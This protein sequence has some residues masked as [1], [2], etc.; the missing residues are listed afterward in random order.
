GEEFG[1]QGVTAGADEHD[2]GRE[3]VEVLE[4]VAPA[5]EPAHDGV[6]VLDDVG[7][8]A[9]LRR[10]VER[11]GE[12]RH[13]SAPTRAGMRSTTSPAARASS[14]AATFSRGMR[15]STDR[16]PE[17]TMPSGS[18]TAA[19]SAPATRTAGGSYVSRS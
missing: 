9:I 3:H 4:Y 13:Q 2:L 17:S 7:E 1:A 18:W 6:P 15:S 10:R 11:D 19:I 8:Q 5:H 14:R 16:P 12:A